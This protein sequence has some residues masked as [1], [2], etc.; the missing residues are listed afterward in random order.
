MKRREVISLVGGA[1]VAWPLPAWAQQPAM[2]V[3]GIGARRCSI[4]YRARTPIAHGVDQA[5]PSP[6]KA[7]DAVA[8]AQCPDRDRENRG[9]ESRN[10]TTTRQDPYDAFLTADSHHDYLPLL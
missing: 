2:P 1:A 5:C 7:D 6:A 8:L 9:I 3:I 10:V 4:I